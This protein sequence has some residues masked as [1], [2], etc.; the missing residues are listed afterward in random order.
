MRNPGKADALN[1]ILQHR[2]AG[3]AHEHTL[4]KLDLGSLAS[5]R[6]CAA[7]INKRVAEG[8]LPPIR[9]LILNAAFQDGS[10]LTMS[11]DAST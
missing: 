3:S 7:Q 5:V 10:D 11:S 6:E 4:V 1:G 8:S 2:R 9:A